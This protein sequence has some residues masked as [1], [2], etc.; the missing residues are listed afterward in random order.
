MST[1]GVVI[2]TD[3]DGIYAKVLAACSGQAAPDLAR[4]LCGSGANTLQAI[5]ELARQVDFGC[6]ECLVVMSS[7]EAVHEFGVVPQRYWDTYW[8]VNVNPIDP[9]GSDGWDCRELVSLA[10]IMRLE[11]A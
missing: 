11:A 9:A 5:Y 4:A 2:I 8:D 10:D 7:C 3:G 1:N 6:R